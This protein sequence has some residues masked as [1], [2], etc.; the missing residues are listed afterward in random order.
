MAGFKPAPFRDIVS[1][2]LAFAMSYSNASLHSATRSNCFIPKPVQGQRCEDC[3]IFVRHY[4]R[5]QSQ[6][7]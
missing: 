7:R 1:E 2:A 5:D 3:D 4:R 6:G